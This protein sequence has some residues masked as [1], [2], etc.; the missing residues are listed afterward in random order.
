MDNLIYENTLEGK[1]P[2]GISNGSITLV[3]C[4]ASEADPYIKKHHYSHKVTT[5]RFLNIRVNGGGDS[6]GYLQLGYGI[7]PHMKHTISCHITKDNYCEFDRMWLSDEMPRFSESQVISLLMSYLKQVYP[8]IKFVITYADSTA[9]NKGTIYRA[10]NAIVLEPIKAD[11]YLL[12]NGERVHPVSMWHR[13]KTRTFSVLQK[14]YPGIVRPKG[15]QH[16]FLYILDRK[17][18]RQYEMEKQLSAEKVSKE[19]RPASGRESEVRALGSAPITN[20][21]Q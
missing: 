17:M 18:R 7:R 9:G 3:E 6:G 21:K 1:K 2:V 16:K 13:H 20:D 11:I 10:T 15:F 4:T 12:P 14:L 5:N 19:T 8:R